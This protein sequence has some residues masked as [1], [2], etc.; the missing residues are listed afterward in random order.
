MA[1][2]RISPIPIQEGGTDATTLTQYGVLLGEG[3][4]AISATTAGTNGQLLIAATTANP[5]FA[6]VTSTNSTI[7]FTTGA[8]SLAMDVN[9][10]LQ[11][12]S[13]FE[14]WGGSG[15]YFDDTTLG[16]FT[17]LRPGTG[18]IKSKPISWLG[19][20]TITG[21]TAGNTYY[22]YIDN[23]GTIQKT[24]TLSDTLYEDN[25]VLF[26]CLRDSTPVT[27]NQ[28]TV[29][30]NHP[31]QFN[32]QAS[33]WAHEV[34]GTVIE[35]NENG[36]NITLNGTQKIQI[37]GSDT[38]ADHGLYTTISDS[39]GTGV[40]FNQEYTTAAGKWALYTQSDTF[41]GEYNN[42]GTP[43]ALDVGKFGVYTLYAS[44][45]NLN[46]AT[47]IYFAVLNTTQYN[48]LTA[49]NTA[50]SNGIIAR[51]TNELMQLEMCQLG[52]IIYS[53]A[54]SSIVQVIIAKATLKQTLSTGGSSVASLVTTNTSNFNAILSSA[55]TNVQAALD[56]IDNW[57]ANA[58]AHYTMVGAGTNTPL[59]GIAPS[60]ASGIPYV[61]NGAS[62]D[63]S[64][65]TAVVAG[66][67]T[68]VTT[69]TT[70][71]APVCAGTTATGPLQVAS[72]GLATAGYVL[73]SNGNAALPSFQAPAPGNLT[74][75]SIIN[76]DSPYTV[77]STDIYIKAD[78]TSGAITVRLA[79]AP[80]TGR[81]VYIKDYAGTAGTNN[82]TITTVGGAVN[83]DGATS[84]VM[85]SAYQS[86]SIVFDGSTYEVF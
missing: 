26:E 2:K 19:S 43:T 83:I 11:I 35:N 37:D 30:E 77:L 7:A 38:L 42:A 46:T 33:F 57:G 1:Y 70:A 36:A 48:N 49:A 65:T 85:S 59:A 71:Y 53:E 13:G 84:Y 56:T 28:I 14:S 47:P 64:F 67:G 18:Y 24:T 21:L 31:F 55:D 12:V 32:T 8:S 61:S 20:Q 72:T 41:A 58:T 25:I 29:K 45:D 22:I 75:T 69:M 79:N 16:S 6:T 27:N 9:T 17:I 66:G 50:I 23:T 15:N 44:K 51:A 4:S 73:T 62:A 60:A 39:S 34:V 76:T 63:P 3:T 10:G 81:V 78:S 54:S 82:I 40:V 52:Y 80:T 68:G 86:A 74:I 5:A